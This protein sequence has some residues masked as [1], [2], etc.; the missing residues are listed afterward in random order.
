MKQQ[1]E[2]KFFT[3]F[4]HE[5]EQEYLRTKHKK[6]WK[7]L[8][9]TGLGTYH[10]EEC[11]PEDVVYQLDYN[12]EGQ[13]HKDE[14]IQMFQD[15]GWEYLMDFYGY[16][17]FRKPVAEMNGEEE[18]FC[19]DESRLEMMNRVYKGRLIP[20]LVLFFLALVPQFVMAVSIYKDTLLAIFLAT[21]IIVYFVIFIVFTIHYNKY[22]KG[23]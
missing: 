6:G 18:I 17:Y 23:K 15:C 3:I 21:I 11:E 22:K 14:Y 12:K 10:F 1:K 16:S 5:Q 19:D 2:T 7:F 9:V 8:K 13:A 20:L 4:Q